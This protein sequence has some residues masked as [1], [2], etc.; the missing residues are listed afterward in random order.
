[1]TSQQYHGKF[2]G[3]VADNLDPLE[4]GRL[5]VEVPQV[6]AGA[7]VWALPCVPYAG[8]QVGFCFLP[9]V[10]ANVWVEFEGGDPY[11]PIWVGCFW[12]EGERPSLAVDPEVKLI[13]TA[14][15]TLIMDDT[16]AEGGVTIETRDP[17]VEVP[18]ALVMDTSGIQLAVEPASLLMSPEEG[19]TVEFPPNEFSLSEAGIAA[20]SG[21]SVTAEAGVDVSVNAG[22]DVTVEA[23]EEPRAG[24]SPC[25][26]A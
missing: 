1:M 7:G 15:A 8:L 21:E 14:T 25:A 20:T 26:S 18:V 9:P 11:Y 22:G 12:S 17:A 16:P 10:G 2:R 19:V 6:P 4:L 24:S 5:Q 13:Q 3:R 23:G